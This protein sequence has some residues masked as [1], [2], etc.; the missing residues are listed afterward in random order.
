MCI[1]DRHRSGFDPDLRVA[2]PALTAAGAL[3]DGLLTAHD[4]LTR[5][6]VT[7]RLVAPDAQEPPPAT[8][9]LIARALRLPDWPAV[10]AAFAATRQEVEAVWRGM[11]GG[12]DG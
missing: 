7:L 9:V 6:L 12:C 4:L 11:T 8:Q 1:R 3:P 2:I 10:L 5:L